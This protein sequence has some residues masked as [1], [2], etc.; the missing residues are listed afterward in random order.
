MRSAESAPLYKRLHKIILL[1]APRYRPTHK[2]GQ[3]ISYALNQW[4]KQLQHLTNGHLEID[5][6]LAENAVRLTKLG[7]KNWIF[8]GNAEAGW[9]SASI[10]TLVESCKRQ[11]LNPEAYIKQVLSHLPQDPTPGSGVLR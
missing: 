3:A 10:Y 5:N 2:L 7:M 8:F 4:D 11:G 1:L 6:N 9:I